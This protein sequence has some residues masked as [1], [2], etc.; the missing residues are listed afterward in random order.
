MENEQEKKRGGNNKGQKESLLKSVNVD[1]KSLPLPDF[2][3]TRLKIW[4]ELKQKEKDEN[5]KKEKD[6]KVTLPDGSEKPAVAFK[7]T[8][9]DIAQSI[10]KGLAQAVVV[11]RVNGQL[12]DTFRPFEEDCSL[13][14]L[15]FDD[16]E[17]KKVFWHS[18][19][20]I[21]GQAL[22]RKYCASLTIGP[23]LKAEKG[24]GFYYDMAIPDADGKP[25][26]FSE[27]DYSVVNGIVQAIVKE[28]QPFERLSLPK[29]E[30]LKMFSYNK[31]KVQLINEKV[32]DGATCT[33]YRCGP[34]IDLC[35][36]PHLPDTGKVKAFGI[37]KNSSAY[38]KGDEKNDSL[39]R[40]Y[41][42]S[43][44]SPKEFKQWEAEQEKAAKRDHRLQGKQQELYFFHNL[45]PG[46][47]FFL[48]K[49]AKVYNT[50]MEFIRSEYRKRGYTEV[51]TPNMFNKNLWETSGH[52][53]N[54]KDDMFEFD[55]EDSTF[56]LKPMNCP[57]HCLMYA[58]KNRSYK[59]LPLRFTDFGVLHRNELSGALT[60]LTRVRRFSQ[61]DGH[62]F[63]RKDQIKSEINGALD[64]LNFVYEKFG[65]TLQLNLST[66]PEKKY[67]GELHVWE[68][69]EKALAEALDGFAGPGNW[70]VKPGDGAFYGPKIDID[71]F[72]CYKR[73]HQCAT[74]QLDFQLPI[75]FGLKFVKEDGTTDG[76]DAIPVII[77]RAILGSFERFMAILVEAT[78]GDWPFWLSPRPILVVPISEKYVDYC[79]KVRRQIFDAGLDVEV[80]DSDNIFGKK[81]ANG[82]VAGYNFILVAGEKEQEEGTVNV[83]TKDGKQTP[84]KVEEFI[85]DC[86]Q[87]K[88]EFK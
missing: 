81:I 35:K 76:D 82:R 74:I 23:A 88:K 51:I 41:G 43:F 68:Q 57:S 47:A 4:E 66:R 44:P 59:D 34:L 83:R 21:M 71:V 63:C 40:V 1:I 37:C 13:Q 10:S 3:E 48:P 84:K 78:A 60:G 61:D 26:R 52:W 67:L 22:E 80:D 32:P 12:W 56:A 2:F 15:K 8:P 29:E 64:F 16:E 49:G 42:M 79:E 70:K 53:A 19:S 14:L 73:K 17:S 50:L 33:A 18:S 38:W 46:C 62:I 54:Y 9:M 31:Y 69:A 85:A 39:Q 27:D 55:V 28:A 30:A 87:L 25:V 65:F 5:A 6:I 72:D 86:L 45:S 75:R 24:G 77:H 20:H 11:A 58:H 36:G 7:T